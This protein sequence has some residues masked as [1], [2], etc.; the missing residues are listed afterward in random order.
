MIGICPNCNQRYSYNDYDVDYVHSCDSRSATINEEDVLKVGNY[1]DE[2][3]GETI[4]VPNANF[5]GLANKSKLTKAGINGQRS[6]TV[7]SRGKNVNNY[8]ERQH[9]EYIE[10]KK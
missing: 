5:Q 10:V 7:N 3:T 2:S 1:V 9:Y 8:R 6:V 4:T